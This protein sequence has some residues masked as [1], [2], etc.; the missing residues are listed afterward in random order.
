V[1]ATASERMASAGPV[2][3]FPV[4]VLELTRQWFLHCSADFA[5]PLA[6]SIFRMSALEMR[7]HPHLH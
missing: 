6:F 2:S 5:V 7:F 3:K 1:E 4:V